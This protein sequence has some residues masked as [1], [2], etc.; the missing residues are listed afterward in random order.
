M[1]TRKAVFGHNIII[2]SHPENLEVL[3]AQKYG[4]RLEDWRRLSKHEKAKLMAMQRIENV[5][6][7]LHAFLRYQDHIEETKRREKESAKRKR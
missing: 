4:Y 3:V 6:E 1:N 5:T 7:M 2:D